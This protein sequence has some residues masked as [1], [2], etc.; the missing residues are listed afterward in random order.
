MSAPLPYRQPSSLWLTGI[1]LV[2][3][4]G[5]IFLLSHQNGVDSAKVS[6]FFGQLLRTWLEALGVGY[7]GGHKKFFIWLSPENGPCYGIPHPFH[8]RFSLVR[9]ISTHSLH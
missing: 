3:W 1:P 4:M 2:L 5:I 8:P 9:P 6:G 7:N